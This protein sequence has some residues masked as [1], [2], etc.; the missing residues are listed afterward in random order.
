MLCGTRAHLSRWKYSG[1]G[2]TQTW[3][4][5]SS[6]LGYICIVKWTSERWILKIIFL[7]ELVLPCSKIFLTE[8]KKK[9]SHIQHS[10]CV[11]NQDVFTATGWG[12][13]N[14]QCVIR[15]AKYVSSSAKMMSKAVLKFND[16]SLQ[17]LS[18]K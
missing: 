7:N 12:V 18:I 8:M 13:K 4:M 9:E 11:I 6:F 14:T 15:H 5:Q 3:M 17:N 2:F 1:A 10:W 16:C